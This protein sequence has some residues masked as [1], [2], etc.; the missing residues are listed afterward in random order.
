MNEVGQSP[1]GKSV[2]YCAEYAPHLLFPIPRADKRRELGL[3]EGALS[4]VGEDIWNAYEISWL[5]PRGKPVVALG[6]FRVPA[7]SP[8]LVESKSLK[9]YLNSLNQ[10]RSCARRFAPICLAQQG[11]R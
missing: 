10:T 1:L 3:E 4:F 8:Y 9:P 7:D 2:S 11:Q 6:E 5:N